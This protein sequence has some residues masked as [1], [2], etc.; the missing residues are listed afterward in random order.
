MVNKNLRLEGVRILFRNFKGEERKYNRAGA[1]N[2]CAVVP[3]K[4]AET[5]EEEGWPIRWLE[6]KREGD[7]RVGLI[8][9]SISYKN[10]N[11]QPTIVMITGKKK[12]K[13]DEEAIDALD[14]AEIE[15]VDLIARPYN[16]EVNGKT[17]VSAY[18][19]TGYFTILE[20]EFYKKYYDDEE[21]LPIAELDDDVPF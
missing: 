8:K 4:Q 5:L 12:T 11:N 15:S 20:D 1:R 6:P 21:D 9:I 10:P 2:F 17:G 14:S 19:K 13:L 3:E 18:L 16:W 7:E